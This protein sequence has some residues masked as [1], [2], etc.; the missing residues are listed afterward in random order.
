MTTILKSRNQWIPAAIAVVTSA[1]LYFFSTGLNGI[2]ALL[3]I[4]PLPVLVISYSIGARAAYLVAFLAYLLG[5]LNLLGYLLMLAPAVVVALLMTVSALAFAFSVLLARAAAV[6][7]KP[8]LAVFAYPFVSTAFEFVNNLLSPNGSAGS[9][10]YTQT[11]FLPLIQVAAITGIWGITFIVT[12]VPAALSLM[13]QVRRSKVEMI[14]TLATPAIIVAAVL[15]FGWIRLAE[16]RTQK[17]I[18]VGLA[19]ADTTVKY[20]RTT[21]PAKSLEVVRQYAHRATDLAGFGAKVVVLPEK[22]AAFTPQSDDSA[23]SILKQTAV[24]GNVTIIAGLD[25]VSPTLDTNSA[26]VFFPDGKELRYY[27]RFLV[28]GFEAGYYSGDE[29]LVFPFGGTTAGVEICKDMDFPSWSREYGKRGVGLLL[30][31]AWDF[32]VDGEFHMRMALLRGVENGFSI[33]RCA[34]QGLLTVSDYRGEIIA[35]QATSGSP[36]ILLI[37]SVSPGPGNTFYSLAGDWLG[38]LSVA[39]ALSFVIIIVLKRWKGALQA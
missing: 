29:P 25:D 18:L 15:I 27:K 20:F 8:W 21:D 37:S 31:P 36:E 13:W 23:C 6:R 24:A 33:V 5:M 22:F 19:A 34:Q 12:L 39:A 2:G 1:L 35:K 3:F 16:P 10:A 28:P 32:T 14:R 38:W 30:V 4:A 11:H 7:L 9:L 17:P 26:V